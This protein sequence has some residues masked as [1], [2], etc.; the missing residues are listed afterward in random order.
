MRVEPDWRWPAVVPRDTG[1]CA[2]NKPACAAGWLCA[3]GISV[4]IRLPVFF[5]PNAFE[6]PIAVPDGGIVRLDRLAVTGTLPFFFFA[7]HAD[8]ILIEHGHGSDRQ[9]RTTP[10]AAFFGEKR[11]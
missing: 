5:Q 6:V 10:V 8:D 3:S 4:R 11:V 1:K 7:D 9:L 2:Q